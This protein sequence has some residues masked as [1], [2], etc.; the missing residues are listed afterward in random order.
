MQENNKKTTV[1]KVIEEASE[2]YTKTVYEA[3]WE[4][5]SKKILFR[6]I[7]TNDGSDII[8]FDEESGA[9]LEKDKADEKIVSIIDEL[10]EWDDPTDFSDG[11]MIKL[12]DGE[13]IYI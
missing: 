13:C 3:V 8:I 10:C 11:D 4:I 12:D 2:I 5:N 1:V 9:W 6:Y 7:E